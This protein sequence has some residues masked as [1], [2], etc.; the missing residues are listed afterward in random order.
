MTEISPRYKDSLS[1]ILPYVRY[2]YLGMAGLFFFRRAPLSPAPEVPALPPSLTANADWEW[3]PLYCGACLC[4]FAIVIAR[5]MYKLSPGFRTRLRATRFFEVSLDAPD[6][7]KASAVIDGFRCWPATVSEM[8]SDSSSAH[9]MIFRALMVTGGLAGMQTNLT[10][11]AAPARGDVSHIVLGVINGLRRVALCSVV[12]FCFAPA[13]GVDHDVSTMRDD[14][15][16]DPRSAT[17]QTGSMHL[18]QLS[19]MLGEWLADAQLKRLPDE[20]RELLSRTVVAGAIHIILASFMLSV[21]PLLELAVILWDG[22]SYSAA[23]REAQPW[24][25]LWAAIATVCQGRKT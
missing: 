5:Q 8:V 19:P 24:A 18:R 11:L 9:G 2:Q 17:L 23:I 14:L 10:T 20:R 7:E 3:I 6:A 1:S 13:G 22:H 16:S 25:L 4:Y 12:G 15:A 21:L